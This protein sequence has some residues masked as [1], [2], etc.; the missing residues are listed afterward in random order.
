MADG[1]KCWCQH[2][3]RELEPSH[4]GPCPYCGKSGKRCVAIAAETIGIKGDAEAVH[5]RHMTPQSWSILLFLTGLAVT[6]VNMITFGLISQW[7]RFPVSLA[8][9]ISIVLLMLKLRRSYRFMG[10]CNYLDRTASGRR[11]FK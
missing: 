11:R 6:A 5:T 1:V 2:C 9:S 10:L 7:Y 4:T 3:E 8:L